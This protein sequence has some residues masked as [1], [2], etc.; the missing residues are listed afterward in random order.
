[1][2]PPYSKSA[3]AF[4]GVGSA[5]LWCF[6]Q[7]NLKLSLRFLKMA[8]RKSWADRGTCLGVVLCGEAFSPFSSPEMHHDPRSAQRILRSSF[9]LPGLRKFRAV[10]MLR[11]STYFKAS[12]S[13]ST[14][15]T[16]RCGTS[17]YRGVKCVGRRVAN[18]QIVCYEGT[19]RRLPPKSRLRCCKCHACQVRDRR[20]PWVHRRR[21]ASAD[22]YEGHESATPAT[23]IE[24][25]VG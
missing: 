21:R 25:G 13:V 14:D 15:C 7:R 8:R 19:E 24:S 16:G 12:E 5:N 2:M 17:K 23:Q 1:M 3:C 20:R 4:C 9:L 6:R 11:I 10:K 18:V 22:I